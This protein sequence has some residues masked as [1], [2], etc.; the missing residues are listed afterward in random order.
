MLCSH[1]GVAL[2]HV[3]Y[4]DYKNNKPEINKHLAQI[5]KVQHIYLFLR[6]YEGDNMQVSVSSNSLTVILIP[7][8]TRKDI[9][10][11][12]VITSLKEVGHQILHLEIEQQTLIQSQLIE[13]VMLDLDYDIVRVIQTDKQLIRKTT[14]YFLD[15]NKIDFSFLSY[16]PTL[17]DYMSAYH[18]ASYETDQDKIDELNTVCEELN[19]RLSNIS[20][21]NIVMYFN[22]IL[23]RDNST[24]ILWKLSRELLHL[25][26][27]STISEHEDTT[28]NTL[29]EQK[30]DKYTLEILWRESLLSQRYG[31]NTED[32]YK[33]KYKQLLAMNF[34]KHVGS[35]EAF[36]LIDG[37]NLRFF[38]KDIDSL[39]RNFYSKQ[40]ES[41]KKI[42][43]GK[44]IKV[45]PAPI[46]VSIFGPQSSGKSTLLNYCFGCKF[47]TSAGRCTRGIYGSLS[48]LDRPVNLSQSFLIL[49]TEG[50]DAIER[51]NIKDTS[52]IHFDRTMVLFCLSVSQVVIINIK[53]DIG[54]EMQNLLQIC[55]YSLDRLKVSKVKAPKIFF[56]LNQQADPDPDKH[57]VAINLLMEKLNSES[58]LMETGVK[59]SDLI[60]VSRENLFI[61]PSAF[62]SQQMNKPDA[63][64]F[65]SNVI[66]LSPT[67]AFA[68]KCTELRLAIINKLDHM[69]VND[70]APFQNMSE[71]MEMAGVIWDTIIKYQD[72]VKYR[73]IEE[74]MCSNKLGGIATNLMKH[75]IY[76]NEGEF[77][78]IVQTICTEISDI[79]TSTDPNIVLAEAMFKF[80][81]IFIKYQNE[82]LREFSTICKNDSVLKKMQ[83]VCNET[84]SNI[85][86]LIYVVRK[87]HEDQIK[88]QIN[89]VLTEIHISES[90]DHFQKAIIE[91]VD[92]Y[93]KLSYKQQVE[94]FNDIWNRTFGIEDHEEELREC[95]ANFSDLYS[96]FGIECTTMETKQTIYSM[97]SNLKF[98]MNSLIENIKQELLY[99]FHNPLELDQS[100]RL[101][102]PLTEYYSPIKA[103]MPYNGRPKYDYLCQDSLYKMERTWHSFY[104]YEKLNPLKWIPNNCHSLIK[105]CSGLENHPDIIWRPSHMIQVTTLTSVLRNPDD[106]ETS[107][108]KKFIN[109]ISSDVTTLL[110]A[111]PSV[112]HAVVKQIIHVLYFRVRLLNYEIG[113]I[114]AGL[115]NTGE[116][117]LSSLVFAYAFKYLWKKKII[118]RRENQYK[119]KSKKR[120]LLQYFFQKIENRKMA[121]GTWNRDTMAESDK[122]MSKKFAFDFIESVKRGLKTSELQNIKKYLGDRKEL[123]S[124]DSIVSIAD[125]KIANYL[126]ESSGDEINDVNHFVVQFI[127]N[128]N[129]VL[130]ELFFE[131]WRR[132]AEK[133]YELISRNVKIAFKEK[134]SSLIDVLSEF[135]KKLFKMSTDK[136][137]LADD[138][139]PE[140]LKK[141]DSDNNF[142]LLKMA[143]KDDHSI[144]KE[145]PFKAMVNYLKMYLDPT[146]TPDEFDKYFSAIF[147][148]GGLDVQVCKINILCCKSTD[149][150]LDAD[151]F[152][153]LVGTKLFNDGELIFNI[154]N[155]VRHFLSDLKKYCIH[156]DKDEFQEMIASLKSD[157][158]TKMIGCPSQCPSCGK[159]CEKEI[160][161]NEGKCQIKTGHQI[162]SMGGKVWNKNKDNTAVL[163]MCDVYQDQTQ[164]YLPSGATKWGEFKDRCGKE[165]NWY[166]P[167]DDKYRSK[168]LSNQKLMKDIWNKFG[169][170]ILNYY[171]KKEKTGITFV[172]YT[173]YEEVNHSLFSAKYLICFVI[174]GTGSMCRDIDRAKVSVGQLIQ[175]FKEKGSSS[176]FRIVIYRDHCD[177]E[178]IETIPQG[179]EFTLQQDTVTEFLDNVVATGGGDFPEAVL[180]GLATAAT[181]SDWKCTP[182]VKNKIIHIYDA[183][184]HG[185]FPDYKSH[186]SHSDKNNCCCCNHDKCKFDWEKDVWTVFKKYSIEYHGINTCCGDES[187]SSELRKKILKKHGLD[188]I[189][190]NYESKMKEELGDLCAD[191]QVVGKEIVNEA[192]VQI[193]IDHKT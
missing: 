43:K 29:K 127:C 177:D 13:D 93:L 141:F 19:G 12:S 160:H 114:Q 117:T 189:F 112:T 16:Y 138:C 119:K 100:E 73:N 28:V 152:K 181:Q 68:N 151:T 128:R 176:E 106:M 27:A 169:K 98:D 116:R 156:L 187:L 50:L 184:P 115:S 105:Y 136:N 125:E 3:Y 140:E 122:K 36:E 163:F 51:D 137:F 164:I 64:L 42:N 66:K 96:L 108:W 186:L 111:N 26:K 190:S 90:M 9:K 15:T 134:L 191:F 59:I 172:P 48:K 71:W 167:D 166:L 124:H 10:Y 139:K 82:C 7:N 94:E 2:I 170:G 6:D 5:D 1:L 17:V 118:K 74:L 80:D 79:E 20:R 120:D 14:D 33:E 72:I 76:S 180:D 126:Q 174:D 133:L 41:L 143:K 18:R 87:Q 44:T 77:T 78:D 97:F 165:W 159:F 121:R 132:E 192:I 175:H 95:Q 188:T 40:E 11:H 103:M 155:Y 47:L 49:D 24:L 104:L 75:H 168:Q 88:V 131:I 113:Y 23:K 58:G 153:R 86:R 65:D 154:Q 31:Q 22:E 123:F 69:S 85:R 145:I 142:E 150:I 92:K 144:G 182:G 179:N 56:V 83:H 109:D 91:N 161:T 183:P 46:V 101:I 54:S 32:K 110:E 130:K 61:L 178:L 162:S 146:V 158:E 135:L 63:K 99:R 21:G 37:D 35:G 171:Y 149:S 57:L 84:S 173:T 89:S 39:L 52:M 38:N 8:L 67:I 60:Q 25:S 45:K 55:A 70:R 147:K 30:N 193:F 81:D 107:T 62:N 157:F 53:G 185:D 4:N 102:Y 129:E 148:I 34:S